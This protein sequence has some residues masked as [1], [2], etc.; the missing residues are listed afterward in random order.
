MD[1]LCDTFD[2]SLTF[3]N[4]DS[5]FGSNS[6]SSFNQSPNVSSSE[7][8]STTLTVGPLQIDVAPGDSELPCM[9]INGRKVY[10]PPSN[11]IGQP[12]NT[13]E[14]FVKHIP[15]AI[16]E[17]ELLN[18]F[19][20][21][22]C[23]YEFRLLVDFKNEN[24]G[25]AYLRYVDEASTSM[26]IELLNHFYVRPNR[27]LTVE[28]SYDKCS[29]FIGNISKLMSRSEIETELFSRFPEL[30]RVVIAPID[31]RDFEKES[32]QNGGFVFMD[33]PTHNAAVRAKQ[34]TSTGRCRLWD[35][36]V[37]ILWAYPK[38][39]VDEEVMSKVCKKR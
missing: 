15:R 3:G 17:V 35:R 16:D 26:A 36:D 32:V 24:R 12:P 30:S 37:K 25:F 33:F 21:I 38:E 1:N 9:R 8:D 27:K 23:I 22:G 6:S 20:R 34:Q 7:N 28:R 10:G 5:G 31:P 11:W 4:F 18:H 2:E 39:P 19:R 13:C 29:L 14:L